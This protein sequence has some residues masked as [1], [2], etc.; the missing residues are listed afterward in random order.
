MNTQRTHSE[1]ASRRL[2]L[3]VA[4]G[5]AALVASPAAAGISVSGDPVLYWNQ[6]L[7]TGLAGSPT[8]TSRGFAMVGVA[9]HDSVNATLGH[10]DVSYLS[11]VSTPGGDTRAAASVAA[12]NVLVALNPGKT[13]EF[14]AALTASLALVPDGAAKTKG[15]ATGA[16]IA[17]AT[18]A[19]RT[20]DGSA[21]AAA[22]PY[23]PSGLPGRWA[24]TPPGNGPAAL[25]GWGAVD[26]WLLDSG[27]Q[28]RPGPPPAIGSAAYAAAYNEVMA[29]GSATSATRSA[30][31]TASAQFWAGAAGTGPWIQAGLDV[32]QAAGLS[33]LENARLFATLSTAIADVAIATW[34]SKY[35]YDYWRPVT[36]IRNGDLDGN[37]ATIADAAWNPLIVTPAFPSY[38]SAHAAVA[39]AASTILGSFLGDGHAFCLTASG[40]TRCFSGYD[41]AATDAA[42]S[43]L[44]GGIHW[45]FD[46]TTGLTTGRAV[47]NYALASKTFDA[48]PEPAA[49]GLMILGFGATGGLLRRRR[50]EALANA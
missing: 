2:G 10:P 19:N 7:S 15:I 4:A 45:S 34:D 8:V 39:G 1:A 30:D 48:V 25:P 35:A 20:G 22:T 33:T 18:I 23:A 3:I 31:Q 37:D 11:G 6:V 26:P 43:R 28:F 32:A 27:D 14:D 13:A 9:L 42:N 5:L 49:W 44:W 29:I 38:F 40:A 17:A 16:A 46:N 47:A 41:Q 24:P 36:G 21:T 12:H 50:R